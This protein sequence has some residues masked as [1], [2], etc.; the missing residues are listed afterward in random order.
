MPLAGTVVVGVLPVACFN[1]WLLA[2][3]ARLSAEFEFPTVYLWCM[4]LLVL[5]E[6]PLATAPLTLYLGSALFTR[7]PEP[8]KVATGLGKSLPQ[9]IFYQVILR[10]LLLPLL[11]TWLI[12]FAAWPYL[13]EV[14][15]LE[16]NPLVA[17]HPAQTT[18]YR[19]TQALHQAAFG[20]LFVRWIAATGVGILLFC[21][22]WM[23]IWAGMGLLF[24]E[25]SRQSDIYTIYYPAAL[26][27]VVGFLTVVRFLSYLDLRIRREGW[28]VELMMRA[29]AARLRRQL[30]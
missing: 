2:D 4:L 11:V 16:R 20:D 21:S 3:M 29:E 19:R 5:W 13:N 26:W 10:G 9:L 23:S 18:T 15:L 14:I 17:R 28:E 25:W 12:L 27:L 24:D 8:G 7:R 6:A 22:L 1:A 30:I